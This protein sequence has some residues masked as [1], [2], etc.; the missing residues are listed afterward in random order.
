M[1]LDQLFDL[2]SKV[3]MISFDYLLSIAFILNTVIV[4]NHCVL[5]EQELQDLNKDLRKKVTSS[6]LKFLTTMNLDVFF[7]FDTA[8]N[9]GS[10]MLTLNTMYLFLSLVKIWHNSF[11]FVEDLA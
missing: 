9:L 8:M 2:K 3:I 10:W 11:F 4:C 5:Q 1:L 7:S 6:A